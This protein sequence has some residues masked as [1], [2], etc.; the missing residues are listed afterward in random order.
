[1]ELHCAS[2]TNTS[3]SDTDS[4]HS[5]SLIK[6]AMPNSLHLECPIPM[7]CKCGQPE[8]HAFTPYSMCFSTPS[9]DPSSSPFSHVFP[10][11]F[12]SKSSIPDKNC[13]SSSDEDITSN[14]DYEIENKASGKNFETLQ[15]FNEYAQRIS[16]TD[17]ECDFILTKTVETQTLLT[18][19]NVDLESLH[20]PDSCFWVDKDI[21]TNK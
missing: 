5:V 2:T 20:L 21:V 8:G 1:M 9:S 11:H 17:D 14:L 19:I 18:L 13:G 12:A 10:S 7:L 3:D 16:S 4:E 15:M 6:N